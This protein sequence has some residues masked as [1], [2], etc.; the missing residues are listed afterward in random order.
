MVQ[1]IIS[2]GHELNFEVWHKVWSSS[3][4]VKR[5]EGKEWERKGNGDKNLVAGCL[6]A[7]VFGT[8]TECSLLYGKQIGE[9]WKVLFVSISILH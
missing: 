1:T 5:K 9:V 6:C 7:S 3:L 4:P 8:K 2:D